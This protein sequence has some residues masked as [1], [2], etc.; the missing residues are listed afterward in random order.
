MAG[1]LGRVRD[2]LRR[3]RPK[4]VILM[5]H[6][7]ATPRV[8]PWDL[9]VHPDRFADQLAVLRTSRRPLALSEFVDRARRGSLPGDAVAVTFD[10]GYADTLRQARPRLAAAGVPATLFLATAF[11]GQSVEYWWDELARGILERDA[12]LDAE[13][14]I[15][16]AR[17]R[18][19]L[20][21][22]IDAARDAATWRAAEPPRTTRQALYYALW[23]RMRALRA[24]ERTAAMS[25]LRDALHLPAPQPD[26]LPM[27]A[28]EVGEL[29]ADPLFEIGGHTATHPALPML[30]PA[31]RRR[32][33]LDGKHACEGLTGRPAAGFA[34]P[35][36]ANDADAR[37]A[38][39]EC[40]FAW[41][42]TTQARPVAPPEPDWYALPRIAVLDW[43]AATFERVLHEAGA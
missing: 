33:I 10:D 15:G 2:R 11:V 17:V 9:A 5:Y 3:R 31:E 27:T 22:V 25:R 19:T 35:H 38:V 7:V 30:A 12:A 18:L 20:P 1:L 40:G 28:A 26:D 43:D 23:E 42:C 13:A 8:D 16:D 41:A 21:G 4:P 6:R 39:A 24:V 32:D 34:Y 36:G 37:A 29:A 14:L